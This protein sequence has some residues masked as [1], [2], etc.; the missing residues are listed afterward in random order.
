MADGINAYEAGRP[1]QALAFYQRAAQLPAGGDQMRVHN[2]L[3]LANWAVGRRDEAEA[4]FSRVVDLGLRQGQLATKLVFQPG[5]T[6]FWPDQA[7]SGAYPLWLRRIAHGAVVR[8]TCI[9][10]TGHTSTSKRRGSTEAGVWKESD[11]VG[12]LSRG[13]AA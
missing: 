5:S 6:A 12:G 9:R 7:V 2:G 3:Y 8:E 13:R 1:W 10:V 11:M 4:A